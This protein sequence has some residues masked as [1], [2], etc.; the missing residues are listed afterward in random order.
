MMGITFR[1]WRLRGRCAPSP[2]FHFLRLLAAGRASGSPRG[3]GQSH[4]VEGAQV[5]GRLLTNQQRLC[6]KFARATRRLPCSATEILGFITAL[7]L[8]LLKTLIPSE[9]LNLLIEF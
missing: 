5:A 1:M 9:L 8:I 7:S 3:R 2:S 6:W 4:N